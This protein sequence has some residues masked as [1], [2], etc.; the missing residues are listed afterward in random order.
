[1]CFDTRNLLHYFRLMPDNRM[2]FGMRGGWRA[3]PRALRRAAAATRRDFDRLFP[4]W[5]GIEAEHAWSGFVC[6]SRDLTP[7]AGPVPGLDNAYAALAYHGNGVAMGSYAG[8]L[9]AGQILDDPQG[10]A[11]PEVMRRPLRRFEL[12]RLRRLSLPLAYAWF[13]LRD[14]A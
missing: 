14:R 6:L 7:F 3:T 4:A 2:L 11:T 9:I 13:G 10:R 12:G 5:R 8:R 1:M